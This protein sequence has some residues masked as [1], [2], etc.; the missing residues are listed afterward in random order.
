MA[1]VG[2]NFYAMAACPLEPQP[3]CMKNSEMTI[4]HF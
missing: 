3:R 1:A 4:V 2:E